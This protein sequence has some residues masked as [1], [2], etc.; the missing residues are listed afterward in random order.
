MLDIA[1]PKGEKK[2]PVV[3]SRDEVW[4]ILNAVRIDAYRVCLTT[5]YA[6]GLRLTEAFVC[7]YRTWTVT[8][9]CSTSTASGAK[10]RASY[11][12]AL[13]SEGAW[14]RRIRVCPGVSA[15]RVAA[16]APPTE[17]LRR[18]IPVVGESA[19]D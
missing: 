12:C 17:R 4:R 5:I 9:R 8:A 10:D 7:R 16:T 13:H 2:L 14:V 1:R 6:C 11:V 19:R 3:L 15:W 18:R